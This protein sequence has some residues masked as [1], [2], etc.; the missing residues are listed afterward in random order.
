MKNK[1]IVIV[2]GDIRTIFYEILF[3]SLKK[4]KFKSPI[5]LITSKEYFIK[6]IKKFSYIKKIE[7][8]T[9]IQNQKSFYNDRIYIIDIDY[10]INNY[11]S[12]CFKEA[13]KVLNLKIT[14]KFINGPINKSS[15][16][17]KKFLGVTEYISKN[18]KVKKNAMLIFNKELSVCPVTTHLPLKLVSK[19]INQKL[20]I[21]KIL[22][23]NNFYKSQLGIKPNIAIAGINPHCE[24][25]LKV[26]EDVNIVTPAI[27]YIKTKGIKVSGPYS[28][29]TLFQKKNRK[30][31]DVIV[32][33]YHDQVLAPFKT[34]YEFD[35]INIT[36]GLPFY[37]VS[38]D[39]G[40]NEKM[41]DMNLS[42]PLSLIR[43]LEFLD[44]K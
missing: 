11:L 27:K 6:K 31:F 13:F 41:I 24:S 26:N 8:I 33:M 35:A 36:L 38:P 21:E 1:P 9:D 44:K 34:I 7:E 12:R 10:K 29:D 5:I 4:K 22:L 17:N 23:I 18:F 37:R 28:A 15:F 19:K 30:K 3:K 42:N 16:L 32:G 14:N 39:H 43:A 20:I 2:P 25:V 40:P